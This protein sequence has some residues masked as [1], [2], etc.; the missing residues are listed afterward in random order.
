[1]KQLTFKQILPYLV[2]ALLIILASVYLKDCGGGEPK[3]VTV[4]PSEQLKEIIEDKNYIIETVIENNKVLRAKNDSL[5]HLKP[6]YIKGRDRIKDSLIYVSDSICINN[7]NVL[8]NEC[9]RVD[10]VNQ[11]IIQNQANQ[12]T[13]YSTVSGNLMDIIAIQKYKLTVD[14]VNEI[15]LK[16]EIKKKYRKGLMQGGAIGVGIGAAFIGGLIIK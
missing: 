5:S 12:I 1:M 8:Y 11:D 4:T 14:S 15:A 3:I 16:R 2:M 7:L 10:S 9:Q 13:N 6:K